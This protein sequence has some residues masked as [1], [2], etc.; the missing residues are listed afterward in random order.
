[1]EKVGR[2]FRSFE[3]AERA[4]R[5]YYRSLTP[6]ERLRILFELNKQ[7]ASSYGDRASKGL[8]RVYRIIKFPKQD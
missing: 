3:E 4:E 5:A 6:E 1:M 2:V 7:W 8:E